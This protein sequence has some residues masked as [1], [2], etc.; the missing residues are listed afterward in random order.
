VSGELQPYLV[1]VHFEKSD[2][3]TDSGLLPLTDRDEG[4]KARLRALVEG[5]DWAPLGTGAVSEPVRTRIDPGNDEVPAKA[6]AGDVQRLGGAVTAQGGGVGQIPRT[7]SA[8]ALVGR[9]LLLVLKSST[10]A[11]AY[12]QGTCS[13]RLQGTRRRIGRLRVRS[14]PLTG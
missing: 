12:V 1:R 4:A 10:K 7:G 3:S 5:R 6:A 2:D 8:L 9:L 13:S 11:R 14:R